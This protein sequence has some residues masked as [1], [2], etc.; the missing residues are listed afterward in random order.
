MFDETQEDY[1]TALE[2]EVVWGDEVELRRAAKPL[3]LERLALEQADER[4]RL[5]QAREDAREQAD[6]VFGLALHEI[7]RARQDAY[8]QADRAAGAALRELDEAVA[9]VEIEHDKLILQAMDAE[10]RSM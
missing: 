7:E 6:Y 4:A 3:A 9:V 2:R 8:K 5:E 10:L 1:L